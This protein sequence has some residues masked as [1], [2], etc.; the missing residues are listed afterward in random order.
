MSDNNS[1]VHAYG[2]SF[3]ERLVVGTDEQRLISGPD[4]GDVLNSIKSN[5]RQ[6][7]NSRVGESQSSP[8]LGLVDFN[9]TSLD[10]N[11][12]NRKIMDG[13]RFCIEEYEP[14]LRDVDVVM[15]A[16][17]GNPFYLNFSIRAR[18]NVKGIDDRISIELLLDNKS[19]KVRKF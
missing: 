3:L 17:R 6:I 8:E 7:L 19:Y 16:E 13:I 2:V 9:D 14:R 11:E 5:I 18:V 15:L 12:L 10:T 1:E 4:I